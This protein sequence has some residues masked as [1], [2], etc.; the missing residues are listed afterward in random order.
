M[1]RQDY[2]REIKEEQGLI[3][4]CRSLFIVLP[5]RESDAEC[6]IWFFFTELASGLL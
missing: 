1:V 4:S 3:P 2:K 5:F 6:H